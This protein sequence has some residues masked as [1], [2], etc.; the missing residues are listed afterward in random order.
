MILRQLWALHKGNFMIETVRIAGTSLEPLLPESENVEDWTISSEN[1]LQRY[2]DKTAYTIGAILGDGHMRYV[3]SYGNGSYYL[4]EVAGM[5]EEII[6]R[7]Q[8]EWYITFGKS[9]KIQFRKLDSGIDFFTIRAS[10]GHIHHYF[11]NLTNGRTEIPIEIIR[12]NVD[13]KKSFVAGLMDTDGTVKL[14]ETWNGSRTKKNPRWQLGF[15]NTELK[16]VES[17]ASLLT[18][19]GVRVGKMNTYVRG[20]YRTS[21]G[22]FPNIRDFIDLGFYFQVQRKQQRLN[23]YLLHVVGSETMYTASVTSDEDI[24]QA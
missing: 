1:L 24:V 23:D 21:Y 6:K 9:Y 5:D 22:I 18:S 20:G 14:T 4:T 11:Y 7:V 17:L 15:V 19:M 3:P 13:I 10:S 2:I 12:S 8:Y 16:I